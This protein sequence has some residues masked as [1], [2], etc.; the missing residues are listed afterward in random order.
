MPLSESDQQF[1]ITVEDVSKVFTIEEGTKV[2]ALQKINLQIPK[3]IGLALIGGNGSGKSTLLRLMAGI[4]KPSYGRIIIH[5]K[6]AALIDPGAGFHPELSGWENLY[7]YGRLSGLT[8]KEIRHLSSEIIEFSGISNFIHRPLKYYSH[9]MYLRLAFSAA[10]F[11]PF[12][13]LLIDEVLAVGD[14]NFQQKCIAKLLELKKNEGRTFIIVSHQ[15]Q[16]LHHLCERGLWLEEGMIKKLGSFE[17]VIEEYYSSQLSGEDIPNT[18]SPVVI[19]K[20]EWDRRPPVYHTAEAA[21]LTLQLSMVE[22]INNIQLRINVFDFKENF[23]THLDPSFYGESPLNLKQ[24][25]ATVELYLPELNFF[26]GNYFLRVSLYDQSGLIC[27]KMRTANFHIVND[28]WNKMIN[29]H[30]TIRTGVYL[31]HYFSIKN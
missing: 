8:D 28:Y 1:L 21:S 6:V 24:G 7:F 20:V 29:A 5:G 17:S 25:K 9:G 2:Q 19:E 10:V 27:R 18:Y 30:T 31:K 15:S 12:D 26:P 11:M 22:T 4:Y 16:I 14:L 13:V 23:I 3:G